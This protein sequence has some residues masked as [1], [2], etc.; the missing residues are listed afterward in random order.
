MT[1]GRGS[2][3]REQLRVGVVFHGQLDVAVAHELLRHAGRNTVYIQQRS[4]GCPQG[5]E[6]HDAAL[7]VNKRDSGFL[8]IALYRLY[9]Q[10]GY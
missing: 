7:A 5:V 9:L 6:I 8:K 4:E 1:L 10:D 2:P 3:F